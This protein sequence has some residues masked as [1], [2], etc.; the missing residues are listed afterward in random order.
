MRGSVCVSRECAHTWTRM[1]EQREGTCRVGDV[2]RERGCVCVQERTRQTKSCASGQGQTP[3]PSPGCRGWG[4]PGHPL[5]RTP[6]RQSQGG[7][8]LS[9]ADD[10]MCVR[11][12]A[13]AFVQEERWDMSERRLSVTVG[14]HDFLFLGHL[15]PPHGRGAEPRG[16]PPRCHV[17]GRAGTGS[18]GFGFYRSRC[19]NKKNRAEIPPVPTPAAGTVPGAGGVPSELS[20]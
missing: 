9:G 4:K 8:S 15:G 7:G 5:S 13:E 11:A 6:R 18:S 1:K 3:G 2:C 17:S 19:K 16:F 10:E 20:S 12:R 14:V